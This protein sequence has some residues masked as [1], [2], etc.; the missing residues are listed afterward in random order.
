MFSLA[1][2]CALVAGCATDAD[3]LDDTDVDLVQASTVTSGMS[4]VGNH[5]QKDGQTWKAHG[6][7]MIGA[8]SPAWCKQNNGV[9]AREHFGSPELETA[10]DGWHAN[11]IRL[12]ISQRGLEDP[13]LTATQRADYL[14]M[15][16]TDVQL[17]R[18]LGLVVI[19]SMQD[20]SVGC[21]PVHPLPSTQ[22]V[23]AWK[24]LAPAFKNWRYVMYELFN[25][26]QNGTSDAA[27][28]QWRD[29]GASP[30]ANLGDTTVGFQTLVSTV[31]ATGANNVLLAD[32]ALKAEHLDNISSHVLTDPAGGHGIAYA[33]HPYYFT[34]D[35][36]YWEKSWG[37]LAA[38][39]ALVATEWNYLAE[40][41]GTA[42]Q[43]L[44]PKF[45]N[46]LDTN[47]IGITAHAFDFQKTL[48]S[49]WSWTPTHC[50]GA[51]GGA[52]Q[53]LKTWFTQH[54]P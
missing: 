54:A 40:D 31:R 26:P 32:G 36:P 20:Q 8:L 39:H 15:V 29:G 47:G 4:V 35:Q 38:S 27:W 22:T 48:V 52:G 53:V 41:C 46:W 23:A 45:L 28:A 12:Q 6:F 44:A 11:A 7:N 51:V 24:V 49:D 34:P 25:E 18:S 33:I 10:I 16:K 17:A 19:L 13:T 21:G 2:G 42:K 5:L 9:A 14:A 37:F 1:I 3:F 30:L 50:G 43:T